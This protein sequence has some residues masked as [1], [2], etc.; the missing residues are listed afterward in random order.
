MT[1]WHPARP[2]PPPWEVIETQREM[3][4]LLP[5]DTFAML[6]CHGD[7]AVREE[8]DLYLVILEYIDRCQALPTRTLYRRPE[9]HT[10]P[11]LIRGVLA[12]PPA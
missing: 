9:A 2:V 4:L 10:R 7:L 8:G 5:L 11:I 3:V 6:V 1:L 12:G